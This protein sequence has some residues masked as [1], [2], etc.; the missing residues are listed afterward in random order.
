MGRRRLRPKDGARRLIE[1]ARLM[2]RSRDGACARNRPDAKEEAETFETSAGAR[3]ACSFFRA[4]FAA[5]RGRL[6]R[7]V[8]VAGLFGVRTPVV[9]V[10]R[11]ARV[12][13]GEG[14]PGAMPLRQS[15]CAA[16]VQDQAR[17][18]GYGQKNS[19]RGKRASQAQLSGCRTARQAVYAPSKPTAVSLGIGWGGGSGQDAWRAEIK[20]A[21]D[22]IIQAP[23][24]GAHCGRT[25]ASPIARCRRSL[26][27]QPPTAW[28]S[29]RSPPRAS[30]RTDPLRR[31]PAP[32]PRQ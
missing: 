4:T 26:A 24:T 18:K 10:R 29:P 28:P 2:Q 9:L 19:H 23:A 21:D 8:T 6:G 16:R 11:W 15:D 25:A 3:R 14:E 20:E 12:Y 31:F 13:L 30:A 7:L 27:P 17:D 5:L 32:S 22:L 1:K